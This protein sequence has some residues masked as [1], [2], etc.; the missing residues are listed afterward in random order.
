MFSFIGGFVL[1][2]GFMSNLGVALKDS[3][4]STE[5]KIQHVRSEMFLMRGALALYVIAL[6]LL[7]V[8][9]NPPTLWLAKVIGEIIGWASDVPVI[10]WLLRI[11]GFLTIMAL[12]LEGISALANSIASLI[13]RVRGTDA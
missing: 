13:D 8:V 3:E 12:V 4:M 11:G 1:Y 7:A 2:S 5:E 6:F 9:L 10:G